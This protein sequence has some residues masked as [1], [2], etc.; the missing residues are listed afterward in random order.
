MKIVVKEFKKFNE[1]DNNSIYKEKIKLLNRKRW[2][3]ETPE[4]KVVLIWK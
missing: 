4:V 1:F 2:K 3:G